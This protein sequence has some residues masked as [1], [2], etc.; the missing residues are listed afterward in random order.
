M[1]ELV[2]LRKTDGGVLLLDPSTVGSIC[3]W[4]DNHEECQCVRIV[5]KRTGQ[6]YFVQGSVHE[7]A[8]AL[9]K[10]VR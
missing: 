6:H 10:E 2:E 3:D 8:I 7:V 9:G 1:A 4:Y 5:A